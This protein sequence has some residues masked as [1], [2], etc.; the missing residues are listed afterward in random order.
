MKLLSILTLLIL[1]GN[2][3]GEGLTNC[4][5]IWDMTNNINDIPMY[6]MGIYMCVGTPSS[7]IENSVILPSNLHNHIEN[8]TRIKRVKVKKVK[9]KVKKVI[10]LQQMQLLRKM[11]LNQIHLLMIYILMM[12]IIQMTF[13]KLK[14]IMT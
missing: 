2:T 6:S 11:K 7:S 8:Q 9:V 1:L 5:K 12:R 14:R 4:K 13:E 10:N 3:Y